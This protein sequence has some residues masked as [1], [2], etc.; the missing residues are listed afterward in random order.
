MHAEQMMEGG[1]GNCL[2][3]FGASYGLLEALHL[4]HLVVMSL[5]WMHVMVPDD[6]LQSTFKVGTHG[7]QN[8]CHGPR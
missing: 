2:T 5:Y 4:A 3:G 1:G 6:K 8:V 7:E